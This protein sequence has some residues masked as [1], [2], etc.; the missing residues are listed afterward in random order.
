MTTEQLKA[1]VED[2]GLNEEIYF[3]MQVRI[4]KVRSES[5]RCDK[6]LFREQQA[7]CNRL[8]DSCNNTYYKLIRF[9]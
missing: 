9:V 6:C 3:P 4:K 1:A 7:I 2:I 8:M 5:T